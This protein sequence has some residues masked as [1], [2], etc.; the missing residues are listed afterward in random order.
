MKAAQY[1]HIIKHLE[2]A[3]LD[4]LPIVNVGAAER[5]KFSAALRQI[6][7][8]RDEAY[9]LTL[10]AEAL[11]EAAFG[12]FVASDFGEK[13][14]V[15]KSCNLFASGRR[16]LDAWHHN[17]SVGAVEKHLSKQ[18]AGWGS[19]A[20]LGF[21]VWLPNRFRRIPAEDGVLFIDSS[22]LFEINP[23]ITK[24]IADQKF[25]DPYGGRVKAGWLLLSRSGQIYGLNG[26]VTLAGECHEGRVVSDDIIRIAPDRSLCRTG[27]LLVA[28]T[29]PHLGRPRVKSLPYGSSIPHIEVG[30]V[31]TFLIPRLKPKAEAEIADRAEKAAQLRNEADELEITLANDAEA[32]IERFLAAKV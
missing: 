6:L 3:H 14:F 5:K 27:Y 24:R 30:D 17:P 4:A 26:S 16:R 13:G 29:H 2:V 25:G 20:E 8:K 19:V 31:E 9:R 15:A 22:D 18:A 21:K 10:E 23:D 12:S 11:F 1:G 28:M 32:I 7:E